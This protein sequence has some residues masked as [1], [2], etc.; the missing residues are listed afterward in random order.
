[1]GDKSFTKSF[2]SMVAILEHIAANKK[3]QMFPLHQPYNKRGRI[4]LEGFQSLHTSNP[5]LFANLKV[6][7]YSK[8]VTNIV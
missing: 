3:K 8:A 2:D 5:Y 6:A 7:G 1:M 4:T